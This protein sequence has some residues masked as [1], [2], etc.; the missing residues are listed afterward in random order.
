MSCTSSPLRCIA[1]PDSATTAILVGFGDESLL[2]ALF[3]ACDLVATISNE[4]GAESDE[5]G[6]PVH[7]CREPRAPWSELWPEFRVRS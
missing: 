6:A 3:T 7:L 2:S 1:P 5:L 4:A